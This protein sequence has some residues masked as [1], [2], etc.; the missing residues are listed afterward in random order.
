MLE[1]KTINGLKSNH[2]WYIWELEIGEGGARIKAPKSAYD[3]RTIKTGR[4]LS[5]E[6]STYEEALSAREK[7]NAD[8][9][10]LILPRGYFCLTVKDDGENSCIN[11]MKHRFNTYTERIDGEDGVNVIGKIDLSKTDGYLEGGNKLSGRYNVKNKEKG[12][13]LQIGGVTD[14]AVYFTGYQIGSDRR[15]N[16][17]SRQGTLQEKPESRTFRKERRRRIR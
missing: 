12:I 4:V 16:K 15:G 1:E 14:G 7:Y 9:V 6:L 5:Q 2:C 11:G 10:G 13:E 17:H 3:C 8:G